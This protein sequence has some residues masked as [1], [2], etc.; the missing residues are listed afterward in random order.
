MLAAAGDG[1]ADRG[2]REGEGDCRGGLG[3]WWRRTGGEGDDVAGLASR[4]AATAA[5]E[6]AAVVNGFR[7]DATTDGGRLWP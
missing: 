2:G 4:S 3:P 7:D 5:I 6:G 1:V